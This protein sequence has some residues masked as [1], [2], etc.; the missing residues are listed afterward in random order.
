MIRRTPAGK[1]CDPYD[2]I[3]HWLPNLIQ[4]AS[5]RRVFDQV[6]TRLAEF[7]VKSASEE[8]LNAS[9]CYAVEHHDE[10]HAVLTGRWGQRR[11]EE[12]GKWFRK[13]DILL[14]ALKDIERES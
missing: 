6:L 12:A 4:Q 13:R 5:N 1:Y 7:C 14:Q 3:W 2:A 9:Q 10:A 8:Y 11:H